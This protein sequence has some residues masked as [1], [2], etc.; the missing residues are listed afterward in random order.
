MIQLF[1]LFQKKSFYVPCEITFFK[2]NLKKK[3]EKL[4]KVFTSNL[5]RFYS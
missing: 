5:S 4:K 2:I 3:N 1:I